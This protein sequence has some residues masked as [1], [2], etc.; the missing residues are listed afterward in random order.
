VDGL[1]LKINDDFLRNLEK[2]GLKVKSLK[3]RFLIRNVGRKGH[4]YV[5]Y[6]SFEA[7]K[8]IASSIL[9]QARYL[10][11]AGDFPVIEN[12]ELENVNLNFAN[13]YQ[14]YNLT[15]SRYLVKKLD[16]DSYRNNVYSKNIVR[17]ESLMND[18]ISKYVSDINN[19]INIRLNSYVDPCYVDAGYV[20][21][22]SEPIDRNT[23][24]FTTPRYTFS[25]AFPTLSIG[26]NYTVSLSISG[27][28]PN[29]TFP[30]YGLSTITQV[31]DWV[32]SNW[33]TYGY[34]TI[35]STGK[36]EFV[37]DQSTQVILT[38]STVTIPELSITAIGVTKPTDDQFG[39]PCNKPYL[40]GSLLVYPNI[41]HIWEYRITCLSGAINSFGF[42]IS[43]DAAG[44]PNK[45]VNTV[46]SGTAII[47]GN[48]I[49]WNGS[50]TAGNYVDIHIGGDVTLGGKADIYTGSGGYPHHTSPG[51]NTLNNQATVPKNYSAIATLVTSPNYYTIG[52][53]NT[54]SNTESLTTYTWEVYD[55]SNSSNSDLCTGPL[56]GNINK[57]LRTTGSTANNIVLSST[58][59]TWTKPLSNF[60]ES[61]NN[62]YQKLGYFWCLQTNT[63]SKYQGVFFAT[64]YD[65]TVS[66]PGSGIQNSSFVWQYDNDGN[67][68]P[69]GTTT[70]TPINEVGQGLTEYIDFAYPIIG[71][72]YRGWNVSDV[73]FPI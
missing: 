30:T 15:E 31:L 57:Q 60:T 46:T 65:F 11:S 5:R 2:R 29:Q 10:C 50:L 67:G 20:S 71:Q 49:T 12:L 23:L 44:C 18:S 4:R 22:N 42:S 62:T 51:I 70:K 38:I 45:Y 56:A 1:I 25:S 63:A 72:T 40:D 41:Q 39:D 13:E 69:D 17:Y 53:N 43:G 24:L 52:G 3:V 8:K 34:W 19:A 68:T 37:T 14:W 55:Y 33:G 54:A 21:P 58:T 26:Q 27:S 9:G 32:Q 61:L 47:G 64:Y 7:Y 59:T 73:Y 16:F 48:T 28:S 66:T 36:L 35:N 6:D